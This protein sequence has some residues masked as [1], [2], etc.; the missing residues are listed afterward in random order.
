[1][2]LLL[3]AISSSVLAAAAKAA[4]RKDCV[5]TGAWAGQDSVT[6][7]CNNVCN[8]EGS[9]RQCPET[10]CLC[11]TRGAD[12][13]SEPS[14]EPSSEPPAAPCNPNTASV[15]V[16]KNGRRGKKWSTCGRGKRKFSQR[17]YCPASY[18]MC[19][20]GACS[21]AAD[22]EGYCAKQGGV[23][24]LAKA[25][26]ETQEPTAG[27]C[28]RLISGAANDVKK[29]RACD[30][31]STCAIIKKGGGLQCVDRDSVPQEN[32]CA[33][34]NRKNNAWTR[35][36]CRTEPQCQLLKR[37]GKKWSCVVRDAP[38]TKPPTTKP[39][40]TKP[41]TT[42]PP[43]TKPPTTKPPTTKPPVTTGPP[44][45]VGPPTNEGGHGTKRV[46]YYTSW[47]QY[48]NG[49]AIFVPENIDATLCSHINYG[50][51]KVSSAF[52]IQPYEWNDE[53][54]DWSKGMF[55]R[56]MAK[57]S[58]NPQLKVL[59]SLGGWNFN[60]CNG[61]GSA[62]CRIFS[63]MVSTPK[64]RAKFIKS[65]I[66][67]LREHGFDGLDLDWEYPVVK[68]HN[69]PSAE[70]PADKKNFVRLLEEAREAFVAEAAST[71]S[72]R[73]LLTA[74]VGVGKATADAAYDIPGLSKNLDFINLMTYDMHG[75]WDGETGHNSPL[76]SGNG[77][78]T[79]DYPLSSTWAVDYWINRGAEPSKLIL[80]IGT[81]GRSFT[82]N[83]ASNHGFR[84][85]ATT[86][87]A[88][89][90]TGERGYWSYYEIQDMID[91]GKLTRKWDD[92]RKVPYAYS[93][94]SKQWVGY[95]DEQSIAL[96]ID[97]VKSKGLGGAMIWALDLDRFQNNEY[98]LLRAINK[99]LL[100]KRRSL[101]GNAK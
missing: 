28:A 65:S 30:R 13:T 93:T 35:G 64:N 7:W 78:S 3:A 74:A 12:P 58:Q 45:N 4:A 39:P 43:T 17:K 85:P 2:R 60:D 61:K 38:T 47:A 62:T 83:D 33:A 8:I 96:K 26:G 15:L 40:T 75:G 97:M 89:P 20:S 100:K 56:V 41:P 57:K 31:V 19:E 34:M 81:Y 82:L 55:S 49:D 95:D 71:G 6:K 86:G 98:P 32:I 92:K 79:Y 84:A 46:C 14:S 16:C 90:K 72:E 9:A 37:R 94:T 50:F 18:G 70:T 27:K 24:F 69:K 73:L 52:E 68:G 42:K 91:S 53:D 59:L 80:G 1:M 25:C 36:W 51:G 63:D 54:M 88:G 23:R 48:R 87:N 5:A 66:K 99:G 10:H 22:L 67:Y 11:S 76:V 101:R 44:T 21:T 29:R 77:W